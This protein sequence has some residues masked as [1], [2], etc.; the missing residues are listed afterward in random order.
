MSV[1]GPAADRVAEAR[2][3][4]LVQV[5]ETAPSKAGHFVKAYSTNSLRAAITANCLHCMQHDVAAIRECTSYACPVRNVRP[6]QN[7][8]EKAK[9]ARSQAEGT[10]HDAGLA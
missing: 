8:P 5:R 4:T 1:T 2:A 9:R 6:Y 7:T 3:H 10:T